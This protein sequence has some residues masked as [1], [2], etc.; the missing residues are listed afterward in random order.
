MAVKDRRIDIRL[1][2]KDYDSIASTAAKCDLTVS[3]FLRQAGLN[4]TTSCELRIAKDL[5][6]S[7]RDCAIIARKAELLNMDLRDYIRESAVE[8]KVQGFKESSAC[9]INTTNSKKASRLCKG[10][11]LLTEL[12]S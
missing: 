8:R 6:L 12:I 2:G 1:N 7:S 11:V 5:N 3:E 10:Q 9:K 4:Y